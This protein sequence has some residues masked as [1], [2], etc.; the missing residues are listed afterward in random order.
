MGLAHRQDLIRQGLKQRAGYRRKRRIANLRYRKPRFPNR[1]R[2]KGWLAPSVQHVVDGQVHL[3]K[4]PRKLAPIGEI[5]IET[6][7]FDTQA[8]KNLEK[9]GSEYQQGTRRGYTLRA[10][11]LEKYGYQRVYCGKKEGKLEIERLVP[12]AKSGSDRVLNLVIACASFSLPCERL[13]QFKAKKSHFL[14]TLFVNILYL[15]K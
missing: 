7:K 4:K 13:Q 1:A 5:V 2:K 9:S 10:C 15:T 3:I 8:I 12:R 11:L 6:T 14:L